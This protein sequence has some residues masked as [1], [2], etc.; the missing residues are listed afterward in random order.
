M[1]VRVFLHIAMED[2]GTEKKR[3][4]TVYKDVDMPFLPTV[5]TDVSDS[6]WGDALKKVVESTLVLDRDSRAEGVVY[7]APDKLD[8]SEENFEAYKQGYIGHGWKVV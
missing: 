8:L 1:N 5:G 7:L 3:H 4:L 2:K 6:H